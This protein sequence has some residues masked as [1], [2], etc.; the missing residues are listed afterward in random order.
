MVRAAN[1]PIIIPHWR[2]M[3]YHGLTPG[4]YHYNERLKQ[5]AAYKSL[6]GS[7]L[8]SSLWERTSSNRHS[9]HRNSVIAIQRSESRDW[10]LRDWLITVNHLL[11]YFQSLIHN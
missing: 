10:L 11:K 6:I 2:S 1:R 8:V 3:P 9:D 7:L 5:L 4:T